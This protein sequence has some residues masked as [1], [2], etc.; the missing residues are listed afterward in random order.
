[1]S[2][3]LTDGRRIRV[4]NITDDYNREALAIEIGLSFPSTRVIRTLEILEEEYGLPEHI[5]VDNGPESISGQMNAWCKLRNI[6]LKFIQPG[7]PAQ[8]AYIER[9]NRIFRENILDAYWFEDLD[10][11]R[12]IAEQWR[13][14]YNN[15]HP[16]SSLNGMS[17]IKYYQ[18]AVQKGNIQ[19]RIVD[20]NEKKLNLQWSEN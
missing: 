15:N 2:D 10:Q 16:H 7:K 11:I 3:A 6:K 14:D 5:R 12:V 4:L 17:P 8:N 18:M 9:F 19:P 13:S 1:M 20:I